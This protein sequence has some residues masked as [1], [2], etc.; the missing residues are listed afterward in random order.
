MEKQKKLLNQNK[1]FESFYPKKDFVRSANI[2]SK[3]I[4]E[5]GLDFETFWEKLADD[6]FWHK[7]WDKVYEKNTP[8]SK[9]FLN[10]KINVSYNCLDRHIKNGKQDKIAFYWEGENNQQRIISYKDLYLEVNRFANV[11]KAKGIRKGD[12]VVINMPMIPEAVVSM[13]ACTRIGAIHIVIFGGTGPIGI[14]ERIVHAKAKLV[15]TS[16]G[17]YR[18]GKIIPYK[19][20]ID[21]ALDQ[22][23][24][25]KDVVVVQHSK[26]KIVFNEKRDSWYHQL[27]EKAKDFC[28][29][30]E[31][32][33]EDILFIL[34]TSGSTGKPKGIVH[35]T[36][37][38]LLGV[39]QTTKWVFDIKDEDIY[40]S[41]ADI[42]WITG[43]SYVVYGLLSNGATQLIYEGAL[44]Y[45][46][47]SRPWE[48]IEKYK[49]SI[50]YTAPT[51]IRT[52]MK[53]GTKWIDKYDLRSLRLLGSI[54]EPMNPDV[55]L[56][57]YNTIGKANCPIVDTWFQTETGAL[58]ISALAGVSTL[59]PGFV[60]KPLPGFEAKVL[61]E[62]GNETK[63]GYLA[64]TKDFP[65]MLRGVYKDETRYLETYWSKWD[66]RYYYTG[67]GAIIDDEGNIKVTGRLDDVIKVSGHRIGSAEI[68]SALIEHPLA[69]EA[70]AISIN[71]EIKGEKIIA[72]VILKDHFSNKK[73]EDIEKE[74]EKQVEISIGPY[75]RPAKI[76]LV[77]ELPKT[78][79]GKIMRRILRNLLIKQPIGDISTLENKGCIP[80]LRNIIE[81]SKI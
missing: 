39:Y 67:D 53:W 3:D 17:G 15:I 21:Q 13:L 59:K 54:G 60:C 48:I 30:E 9:W 51:A 72:F 68:E 42:G 8:Y 33:S 77:K 57:Y 56:W 76:F 81:K 49:V 65:S 71:D 5:E 45:P 34:Y 16:D 78:K 6:L 2:K 52:F 25:V 64:L 26:S 22:I 70:S 44:N 27:I 79:S 20:V 14:R 31:M 28:P 19:E 12:R 75:A 66:G 38:Y 32:D 47:Y 37:G 1:Y 7:K 36:A 43:H 74:L 18:K 29:V 62:R 63:K 50:F 61:D 46:N 69:V 24:C 4:Y 11:L 41:T 40:W 55:W 73:H 58:V 35:T 80:I 10:G 23:D